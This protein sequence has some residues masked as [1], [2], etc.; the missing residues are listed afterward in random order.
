MIDHAK[1]I[2]GIIKEKLKDI[3][4]ITVLFNKWKSRSNI[5][6]INLISHTS[7]SDF[8][9]CLIE[10]DTETSSAENLTTLIKSKLNEFGIC[11]KLKV[12]TADGAAKLLAK[13][14]TRSK[15]NQYRMSNQTMKMWRFHRLMMLITLKPVLSSKIESDIN[16]TL[17]G[18]D[19][20]DDYLKDEEINFHPEKKY[21]CTMML[22][23]NI[24]VF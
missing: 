17:Q 13:N 9:L 14:Q 4:D 15:M 3:N 6:G 5:Q 20:L 18:N 19:L 2:K 22:E 24:L 10:I 8:N 16:D 1:L 11:S 12:L 7:A 21:F 23:H